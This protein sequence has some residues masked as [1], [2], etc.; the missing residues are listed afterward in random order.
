[1]ANKD[2]RDADYKVRLDMIY[3]NVDPVEVA[4]VVAK[5]PDA[6]RRASLSGAIKGDKV[7]AKLIKRQ[8]MLDLVLDSLDAS[9]LSDLA[10]MEPRERIKLWSDLMEYRMPK[11]TRIAAPEEKKKNVIKI[12]DGMVMPMKDISRDKGTKVD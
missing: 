4:R 5:Q 11:Y 2:R 7:E 9:L 10:Q 6:V 1:M 3:N 8:R 12:L